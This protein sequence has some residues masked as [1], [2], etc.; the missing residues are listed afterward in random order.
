MTLAEPRLAAKRRFGKSNASGID[1]F[2]RARLLHI[3]RKCSHTETR[4]RT[5]LYSRPLRTFRKNPVTSLEG[6]SDAVAFNCGIDFCDSDR[7]SIEHEWL[8]NHRIRRSRRPTLLVDLKNICDSQRSTPMGQSKNSNGLLLTQIA[9]IT[10][11]QSPVET[12]SLRRI[13]K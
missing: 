3:F 7:K 13:G 6:N 5:A 11:S 4:F 10:P 1:P 8:V 9:N 12:A 2:L